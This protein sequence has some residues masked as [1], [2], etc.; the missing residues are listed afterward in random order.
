MPPFAVPRAFAQHTPGRLNDLVP[1]EHQLRPAAQPDRVP[2]ALSVV[3][4]VTESKRPKRT[5]CG[6]LF[7][8]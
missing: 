3:T 2:F 8:N 4:L 7:N 5:A 1:D 6:V